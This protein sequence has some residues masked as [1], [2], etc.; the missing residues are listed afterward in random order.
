M[1][2]QP[3]CH[4]ESGTVQDNRR[5]GT[6]LTC[7]TAHV[8]AVGTGK[9]CPLS[10]SQADTCNAVSTH[11][12]LHV[13]IPHTQPVQCVYTTGW[14]QN[15]VRARAMCTRPCAGRCILGTY[16]CDRIDGRTS[17]LHRRIPSLAINRLPVRSMTGS[18]E[19]LWHLQR[20]DTPVW[21]GATLVICST[22]CECLQCLLPHLCC[23][24]SP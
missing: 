23:R 18:R 9:C 13:I 24:R 19:P 6:L 14:S 7:C 21:Q 16:H 1:L 5:W 8:L 22:A 10:C 11:T 12:Q 20:A 4:H 3:C 15:Q 17:R 2:A